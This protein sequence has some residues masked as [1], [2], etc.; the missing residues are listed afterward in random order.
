[1]NNKYSLIII[2]SMLSFHAE[3]GVY[4]G[5]DLGINT[6]KVQKELTYPLEEETPTTAHFNNAYTNFHGQLLAGFEVWLKPRFSVALEADAELFTGASRYKINNWFFTQN[7]ATK[8]QLQYGF[9]FFLLPAY[10]IN[11]S[12]RLF[13][14]PGISP[15]Y[16]VVKSEETA[17][18]VGVS[19]SFNQWLTGGGLKAGAITR[20]NNNLDLVLTYQFMQYN[21]VKRTSIEPVSEDSLRGNYKPNVN[22][23]LIGLRYNFSDTKPS[24]YK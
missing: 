4:T 2:A 11:E 20:L 3:A 16:F 10:Q 24:Q 8:E 19:G 1:M 18:N 21:S 6:V 14:G 7:V 15:S 22:S 23:V 5:I 17:G 12:V 13:V 9:S